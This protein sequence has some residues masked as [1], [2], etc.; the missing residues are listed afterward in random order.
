M[1]LNHKQ[2]ATFVATIYWKI[3]SAVIPAA[4]WNM[5]ESNTVP[6]KAQRRS[7]F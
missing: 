2:Q 7:S 3:E 5:D 4:A 6:V 1:G